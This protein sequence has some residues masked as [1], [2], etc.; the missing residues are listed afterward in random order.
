MSLWIHLRGVRL[1]VN[2]CKTGAIS[3]A[4][5][6]IA[7]LSSKWSGAGCCI[8]IGREHFLT[9]PTGSVLQDPLPNLMCAH[10]QP[11]MLLP[12]VTPLFERRMTLELHPATSCNILTMKATT[13]ADE[14]HPAG[15][16]G[17]ARQEWILRCM[18]EMGIHIFALQETRIRLVRRQ[19]DER[20]FLIQSPATAAGH[21]GI[22][23][24]LFK[25]A[26][27]WHAG[28]DWKS[29]NKSDQAPFPG[30]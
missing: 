12:P 26:S 20:Y 22:M 17:P 8:R 27:F 19:C 28:R 30:I 24:G 25:D 14:L 23:I 15:A 6:S 5:Y 3:S 16:E 29:G 18:D 9:M 2:H 21:F 7:L 10:S 1:T 13:R 4:M 11:V